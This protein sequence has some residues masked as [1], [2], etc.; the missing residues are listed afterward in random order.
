MQPVDLLGIVEAQVL[1]LVP[2]H[3]YYHAQFDSKSL[4]ESEFHCV[5]TRE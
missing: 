3:H 1:F 4:V 5:L 2:R